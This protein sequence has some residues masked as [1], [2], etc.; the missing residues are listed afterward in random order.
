MSK[1]N[2]DDINFGCTMLPP[3]YFYAPDQ[4]DES[5]LAMCSDPDSKFL[6]TGDTSGRIV[7]WDIISYC[8]LQANHVSTLCV[9]SQSTFE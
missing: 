2:D 9:M 8:M 7:V 3:G 1:R 5:V 4:S 6:V